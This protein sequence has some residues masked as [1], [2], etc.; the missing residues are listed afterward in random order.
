MAK[1][2]LW[3]LMVF[4]FVSVAIASD[5]GIAGE[6]TTFW[7]D[8]TTQPDFYNANET[9]ISIMYPNGSMFVEDGQTI[10][11]DTGIYTFNVILDNITGGYLYYC[12]FYNSTKVK[13]ATATGEKDVVDKPFGDDDV[14]PLALI[15][16]AAFIAIIFIFASM[17]IK[18]EAI[19]KRR[20]MEKGLLYVTG[21]AFTTVIFF[22]MKVFID[23]TASFSYLESWAN[24]AFIAMLSIFFAI[25]VSYIYNL[26][27]VIL[28]PDGKRD[29]DE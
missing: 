4:V 22:L 15:A 25:F 13:V 1:W 11:R 20:A 7:C 26:M 8:I 2:I 3:L 5:G 29:K 19:P 17:S 18:N 27:V 16:G 6:N 24:Y 14:I 28:F 21:I 23:N 10:K 9:N 12:E